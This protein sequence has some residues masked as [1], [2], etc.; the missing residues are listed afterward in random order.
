MYAWIFRH[1]PGPLWLRVLIGMVVIALVVG[2][3]FEVVFPWI[4][5]FPR[6]SPEVTV[7]ST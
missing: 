7:G 6:S 1:L 4:T 5:N 2:V 3:L